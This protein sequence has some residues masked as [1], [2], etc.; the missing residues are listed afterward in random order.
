MNKYQVRLVGRQYQIVQVSAVTGQQTPLVAYAGPISAQ[1]AAD[2]LNE[3]AIAEVPI[4]QEGTPVMTTPAAVP[5]VA[6]T[7]WQRKTVQYELTWLWRNQHPDTP[8]RVDQVQ[9]SSVQRAIRDLAARYS[10]G[11]AI[12]VLSAVPTDVLELPER[13]AARV[14][15]GHSLEVDPPHGLSAASRWTCRTCGDAVLMYGTNVYGAVTERTCEQSVEFW[16]R[17]G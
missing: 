15:A 4:A 12:V 11:L 8:P 10:G 16:N 7:T 1:L 17:A 5:Q 13:V 14:Q 2:A 9:A 3:S 6:P